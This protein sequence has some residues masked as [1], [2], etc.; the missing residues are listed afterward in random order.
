M[1]PARGNWV[2][3][4]S[5]SRRSGVNDAPSD[6]GGAIL[7]ASLQLRLGDTCRSLLGYDGHLVAVSVNGVVEIADALRSRI[8]C[9]FQTQGPISAEPCIDDGILY[10][11]TRGQLSAYALAA[12]TL[13]TPHVRPLWQ[14]PLNGTPIQALTPAGNRLYVTVA[15]AERREVHV[16]VEQRAHLVHAATKVSWLAADGAASSRAVFFSEEERS[17]HLH[18]VRDQLTTLP[19]PLQS[20][21]EHPIALLG[22]TVFAVFGDARRLYRIDTATG[23]IEEPLDEDTQMFALTHDG[24]EWD[25]DY[26]RIDSGAIH[27]SRAMVRDS[28]APHERAWRG[29]PLIVGSAAVTVGMEDGRVFIYD[30]AQLPQHDIWRLG[31]NDRAPITALASFDSFI[32]AGNKDGLVE[33]RELAAKG[34]A[35]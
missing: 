1:P 29:S 16:V 20:I 19:L 2:G 3:Y 31:G 23:S 25:R 35:Q 33:V 9:R 22:D 24:E 15:A 14:L 8:V 4:K 6:A 10:I 11:G 17:V 34:G 26:V 28:F 13:E 27:F 18:V 30:L 5:G 7:P 12:M 21:G 32:A